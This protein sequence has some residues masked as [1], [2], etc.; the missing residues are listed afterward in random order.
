MQDDQFSPVEQRKAELD[1]IKHLTTLSTGTV[2]LMVTLLDKVAKPPTHAR[3]MGFSYI[4]FLFSISFGTMCFISLIKDDQ[5]VLRQPGR[6]QFRFC[7]VIAVLLFSIGIISL[8]FFGIYNLKPL[9]N[10]LPH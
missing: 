3:L 7:Y 6:F 9:V 2:V 8:A 5:S 1:I 4:S 10:G